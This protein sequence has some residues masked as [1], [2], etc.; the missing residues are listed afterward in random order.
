MSAVE[1]PSAG[2]RRTIPLMRF[3]LLL[4][5]ILTFLSGVQ[6]Y[7]LTD[8]TADFFAWTIA[9][10][11]SATIIGAF[12]W[13]A[14]VLSFLSWRQHEWARARVG[15]PGVTLFLWATLFTTV[16]H[17]D[18]FH[19][20]ESFDA[21]ARFAA[22]AWLV[23]Y[24]VDPLLVTSALILQWRSKGEDAPRTS[25]LPLSYRVLLVAGTVI[26]VVVGLVMLL[27][28]ARAVDVA[29]WPLTALTSR[30]IG[31][32]VIAMGVVFGTMAWDNDA[33]RVRPAAVASVVLPVLVA[34]GVLRYH[35]DFA[36][37]TAAVAAAGMVALVAAIG[38]VGLFVGRHPAAE[39]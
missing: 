24:I 21:P 32:W 11:S 34:I 22:W 5:A 12:Y 15:V 36:S 26:F 27:A 6:L 8:H 17:A 39:R 7:V 13:T 20:A 14:T 16:A 33:A 19:F 37:G 4:G 29:P 1:V 25:P 30:A 38:I 3:A 2:F 23:I 9:A 31:S 35:G 18:K 10:G 28:P